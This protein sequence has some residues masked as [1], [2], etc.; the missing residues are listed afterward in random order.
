MRS[1]LVFLQPIVDFLGGF[2]FVEQGKLTAAYQEMRVPPVS[3]ACPGNDLNR[4]GKNVTVLNVPTFPRAV[5]VAV[6]L[7]YTP[8]R[9]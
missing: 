5:P 6:C 9:H 1:R 4:M 7:G 2:A 3:A 8:L